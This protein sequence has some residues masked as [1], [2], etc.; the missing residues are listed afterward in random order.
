M[1]VERFVSKQVTHFFKELFKEGLGTKKIRNN[2]SKSVQNKVLAFQ[3]YRCNY[4]NM[5]LDVVNFDH[6]NGDS[7]NNSISNCQA[8]CPNCHARKTR[9]P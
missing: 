8:L 3:F 9:L 6:I 5:V 1:D 4:C 2:F 7:A